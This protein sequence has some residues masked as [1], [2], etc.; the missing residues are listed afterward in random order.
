MLA[1]LAR[2]DWDSFDCSG[3]META[4]VSHEPYVLWFEDC[5]KSFL[6][7][8]G[9]K[10]ASLGEMTRAGIRV[11]PG[12]A[13]T[14]AAYRDFINQSQL[15]QELWDILAEV[16]SE[17]TDKV[18][19]ASRTIRQRMGSVPIPAEIED[20]VVSAYDKLCADCRVS[21][22]PVAVRSSATAEDLPGV[23]FAGQQD[24]SLWVC[25]S[26][27]VLIRITTCWSS[28]FT[29]RAIT[30]RNKMGFP[31]DKVFISVGVQKMVNASVA[32][33]MFTLNPI[34]GDRSKIALNASWGLGETVV[35][36]EVTPD[37]WIVD[38]FTFDVVKARVAPKLVE[39]VPL[40]MERK[41]ELRDVPME[42]QN[43]ACLR[44]EEITELTRLGTVIEEHYGMPQDIEWAIDRDLSFPQNVFILQS[45]PETVWSQREAK[46]V[47]QKE[48][49]ALDYILG[50]LSS[51]VKLNGQ[52]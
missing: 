23:S 6:S 52:G 29:A 39:Y 11:P 17:E 46:P 22:L 34:S 44:P 45:R 42:R 31:H 19:W 27:H 16:E 2:D 15:G 37:E 49:S 51:G 7:R 40:P 8:V 3:V 24:T 43:V 4:N 18:E 41:A 14:T 33:V 21:D 38:K 13:L 50:V 25:S 10:N 5:D 32:G 9:G 1:R 20:A 35:S 12:F 30:Y 28:L 36:G 48:S 47:V 26:G